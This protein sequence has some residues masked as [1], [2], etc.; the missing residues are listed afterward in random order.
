MHSEV[1]FMG[2]TNLSYKLEQLTM[3][4]LNDFV[5]KDKTF[6]ISAPGDS[7]TIKRIFGNTLT[8]KQM[9]ILEKQDGVLCLFVDNSVRGKWQMEIDPEVREKRSQYK[10]QAQETIQALEPYIGKPIVDVWESYDSRKNIFGN[11][12]LYICCMFGLNEDGWTGLMVP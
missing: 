9:A 2:R 6:K 10:E 3:K 11:R 12:S 8:P 5:I 7:E 1:N 4:L